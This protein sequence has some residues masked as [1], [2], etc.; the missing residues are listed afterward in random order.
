MPLTTPTEPTYTMPGAPTAPTPQTAT[1]PQIPAPP[2]APKIAPVPTATAKPSVAT[3]TGYNP[4]AYTVDPVNGTVAGRLDQLMDKGGAYLR[5]AETAG[6]QK[7]AENGMLNSS[8]AAGY[9]TGAAIDRAAPIA[10]SDAGFFNQAMTNTANAEN[11]QRQFDAGQTN[12]VA[13]KNADNATQ[14]AALNAQ[15]ANKMSGLQLDADTKLALGQLDADTRT[16]LGTMDANTKLLLQTN[17]SAGDMYSNTVRNIS[18]IARDPS[19]KPD[20]KQA[21]IDSQLNMLNQGLRQLQEVSGAKTPQDVDLQDYFTKKEQVS[22]MSDQQITDEQTRLN[23]ALKKTKVNT[24]ERR[25]AVDQ[26]NAFNAMV[27]EIRNPANT[28]SLNLAEGF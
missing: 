24:V 17:S 20:A 13:M 3:A 6:L 12:T 19:L 14:V 5:R 10:T 25:A 8:L 28:D 9:S 21:A 18:D 7:A 23:A 15:E 22:R 2:V 26:L 16:R 4:A 11:A 1:A 27:A